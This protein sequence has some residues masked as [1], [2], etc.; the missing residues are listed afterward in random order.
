MWYL[1]FRGDSVAGASTSAGAFAEG[2][3]AMGGVR[4][5]INLGGGL[6]I[7]GGLAYGQE[8]YADAKVGASPWGALAGRYVWDNNAAVKPF[9]EIGGWLA[10]GEPMS[11]S[12]SYMNGAG[13]ATGIG[14]TAGSL[15][16]VYGRTGTALRISTTDE[17]DPA[18]ELGRAELS[19]GG[20]QETLSAANPFPAAVNGGATAATVGKIEG[21][22]THRFNEVFEGSLYGAY[23]HGWS[24]G[25][26]I[27][28]SVAGVGT[29]TPVSSQSLNWGEYG[30]QVGYRITSNI[31]LNGFVDGLAGGDGIGGKLHVGLGIDA[32]F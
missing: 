25:S 19:A 26:G 6:T 24:G 21:T 28:A 11:F 18:L 10:P 14:N 12:R 17:F 16:Y 3:S 1:L 27:V 4:G 8:G 15:S 20:Y 30:V 23:A 2:G 7:F 9:V 22:W 31:K 5:Q 13:T 29:F 32:N